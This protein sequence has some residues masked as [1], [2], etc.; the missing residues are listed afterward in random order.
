MKA[1]SHVL[2]T[3]ALTINNIVLL[4][5]QLNKLPSG[6]RETTIHLDHKVICSS[7][8]QVCN[9]WQPPSK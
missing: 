2:N 6:L 9:I 5:D 4:K 1:L 3:K 8:V 7:C